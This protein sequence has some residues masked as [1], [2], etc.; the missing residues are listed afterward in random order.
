MVLAGL[1]PDPPLAVVRGHGS[2]ILES[3]GQPLLESVGLF[4][5]CLGMTWDKLPGALQVRQ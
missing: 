5:D 1:R 4:R 3:A 2:P